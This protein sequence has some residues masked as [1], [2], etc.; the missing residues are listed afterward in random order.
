MSEIIHKSTDNYLEHR[1]LE[2]FIDDDRSDEDYRGAELFIGEY[3]GSEPD[4]RY[5]LRNGASYWQLD[6]SPHDIVGDLPSRVSID[7]VQVFLKQ[8]ADCYV[9][10]KAAIA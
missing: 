1:G 2:A 7:G 5:L 8:Y 6:G 9:I 3:D 4:V 10:A